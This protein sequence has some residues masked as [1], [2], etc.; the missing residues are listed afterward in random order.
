MSHTKTILALGISILI[1]TGALPALA[2]TPSVTKD[3]DAGAIQAFFDQIEV[4]AATSHSLRE[5]FDKLDTICRDKILDNHPVLK[6]LV[7]RIRTWCNKNPK[8]A[9]F[10]LPLGSGLLDKSGHFVISFGT[11]HRYNPFK[12]NT[13]TLIKER[14]SL[15]HY[16]AQ[17]NLFKGRTLILDRHPFGI[18]QRVIGPQVGIMKGFHGFYWD[19]ESKITDNAFLFFMGSADRI[20]AF[21]ITPFH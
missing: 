14:L 19:H 10:G 2:A 16:R 9:L 12:H 3:D 18:G 15:W 7:D 21:D 6:S 11:Y 8:Y 5:F 17:G 1:L 13:L 4:A 20:H